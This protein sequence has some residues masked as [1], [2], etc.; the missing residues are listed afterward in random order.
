MPALMW[1][2]N[3]VSR[4]ASL[5]HGERLSNTDLKP[6]HARCVMA[7]CRNPGFSQDQLAKHLCLDKSL[8]ARHLA[9]LEEH[10]Y[11]TRAAG[12]DKR[13]LLVYPTEKAKDSVEMI[14]EIYRDWNE[15]LICEF[16]EEEQA[17]FSSL[18]ERARDRAVSYVHGEGDLPPKTNQREVRE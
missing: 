2:L 7:V 10:G 11:V 13:V 4:C 5:Y 15:W 1:L 16:T 9:Y 18:L 3:T 8:I 6:P 12:A 14:R 17:L